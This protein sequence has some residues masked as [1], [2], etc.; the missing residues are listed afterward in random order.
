M[1]GYARPAYL[2]QDPLW[3]GPK[4]TAK[5]QPITSHGLD[6]A[7]TIADMDYA[8]VHPVAARD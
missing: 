8:G 2:I 3:G 6:Q 4:A 7:E 1:S 5:W